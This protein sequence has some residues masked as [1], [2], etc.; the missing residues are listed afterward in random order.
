MNLVY[1]ESR[2]GQYCHV[3]K[4]AHPVLAG[5]IAARALRLDRLITRTR[6][7]GPIA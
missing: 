4:Y 3:A 7:I 6:V 1:V 2:Q 5:G